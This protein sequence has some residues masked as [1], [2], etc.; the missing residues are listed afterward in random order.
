MPHSK[1]VLHPDGM[2]VEA[3]V[4]LNGA[5]TTALLQS[6]Q[7]IPSPIQ[8]RALI[9]SG[10]DATAVAPDVFKR[11]GLAPLI[12]ASSQTAAGLVPVNLYRISL[13]IPDPAGGIRKGLTLP[14]LLVSELTASLSVDVLIGLDVLR[15]CLL[16]LD[17][18]GQQ[19]ILAF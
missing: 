18:P 13:T 3:V 6:G 1:F 11:L 5:D 4:G 16:V 12:S 10:A 9:D 7:A 15:Q 17:G 19:F 2:I 14:D 8:L